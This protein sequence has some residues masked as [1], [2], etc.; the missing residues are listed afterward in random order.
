[1]DVKTLEGYRRSPFVSAEAFEDACEANPKVFEE[2]VLQESLLEEYKEINKSNISIKK[3]VDLIYNFMKTQ[4]E[5]SQGSALQSLYE[6][7]RN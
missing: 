6:S 5:I 4:R 7:E 3:K 1:M 2:L